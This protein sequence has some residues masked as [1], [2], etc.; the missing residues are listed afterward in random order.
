MQPLQKHTQIYDPQDHT[1]GKNYQAQYTCIFLPSAGCYTC[2]HPNALLDTDEP[3][4][5]LM[6]VYEGESLCSSPL[7]LLGQRSKSNWLLL[8]NSFWRFTGFSAND[9]QLLYYGQ[10]VKD[11]LWLPESG[12]ALAGVGC[13]CSECLCVDGVVHTHTSLKSTL[14][15][16]HE[17]WGLLRLIQSVGQRCVWADFV[18]TVS[19][20][21]K[22]F[23]ELVCAVDIPPFC[24][25][26]FFF[27]LLLNLLARCVMP[28]RCP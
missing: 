28:S 24:F 26:F 10:T 18:Y 3:G 2:Y 22:R 17:A 8:L 1:W 9:W 25:F 13:E 21:P 16:W 6:E 15:M 12:W 5:K 7:W 23:R 20:N 19:V 4:L 27:P 14:Q 11:K